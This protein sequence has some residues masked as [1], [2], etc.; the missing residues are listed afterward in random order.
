MIVYPLVQTETG[1]AKLIELVGIFDVVTNLVVDDARRMD[2]SRQ[3]QV[4]F[5]S[6]G[7]TVARDVVEP[8]LDVRIT[9]TKREE[10]R[11]STCRHLFHSVY[12]PQSRIGTASLEHFYK[13]DQPMMRAEDK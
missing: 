10:R 4:A 7:V 6:D 3:G 11:Y 8:S 1:I 2:K 5:L 9:V 12:S 13:R